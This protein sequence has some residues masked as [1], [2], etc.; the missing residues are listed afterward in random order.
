MEKLN[1]DSVID[2]E[3]TIR[4]S[5]SPT[6]LYPGV[7]KARGCNTYEAIY[8]NNGRRIYLGHF[9]TAETARQ[10]ILLSQAD[11]LEKKARAYRTEAEMLDRLNGNS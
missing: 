4:K 10:A 9:L 8:Q 11:Y 7:R 2:E 3:I 1:Y 5:D 6:R